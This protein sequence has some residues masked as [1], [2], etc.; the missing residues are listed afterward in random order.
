MKMKT[1]VIALAV[2]VLIAGQLL[3]PAA[4][5]SLSSQLASETCGSTYTVQP[6]DNL[7]KI[8]SYCGTTVASILALNPQ[9]S[10]PNI[11]FRGQILQITGS[12]SDSNNYSTTYTV[13]SGD[14]LSE[15]ATMFGTTI[16]ALKQANPSL[17][18]TTIYAGMVLNIP[19]P[20]TNTGY[21]RVSLS[22]TSAEVG[23]TITVYVRGFPANSTID[24]RVGE[25]GEDYSAVYDGTVAADGTDSATITIPSDADEGEYWVVLVT[26]T[27]QR[28]GVEVTS[29]TIY[30]TD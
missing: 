26:T 9:I 15:I 20:S 19:S 23:D 12:S 3:T 22:A 28:Y 16:W 25:Q 30:I 4:A 2:A 17:Y 18:Y 5:A 10:N 1:L 14:T 11:I 21:A 8:A 27:S 24:Y 7:S 29:H 6:N 13:Q